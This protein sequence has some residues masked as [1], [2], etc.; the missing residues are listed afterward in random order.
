MIDGFLSSGHTTGINIKDYKMASTTI[1][2]GIKDLNVKKAQ[3]A[4]MTIKNAESYIS[5]LVQIRGIGKEYF[6]IA[7]N[8]IGLKKNGK[9]EFP[10]NGDVKIL[11]GCLGVGSGMKTAC[12]NG[13]QKNS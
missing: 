2:Q 8:I 4:K 9:N 10:Y 7:T 3:I 5:S 13:I 1:K 12:L 6:Y 11:P